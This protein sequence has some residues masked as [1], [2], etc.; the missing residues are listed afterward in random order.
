[1]IARAIARAIIESFGKAFLGRNKKSRRAGK[2]PI[3]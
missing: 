1:M 2:E 3:A